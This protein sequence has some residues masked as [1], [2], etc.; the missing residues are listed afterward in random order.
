MYNKGDTIE[1]KQARV[2]N[3][4][5]DY[6]YYN[7]MPR[8]YRKVMLQDPKHGKVWFK[9]AAE[10]TGDLYQNILLDCSLTV[11]GLGSGIIFGKTPK[12]PLI[13]K[14]DYS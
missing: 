4:K 14:D 11:S 9:S 8:W 2:L 3:V 10:F 7:G 5:D 12:D 1:L 13:T 6:D